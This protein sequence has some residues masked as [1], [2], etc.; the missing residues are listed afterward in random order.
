MNCELFPHCRLLKRLG[1]ELLDQLDVFE[2]ISRDRFAFGV[3]QHVHDLK[4]GFRV[5]ADNDGLQPLGF[6]RCDRAAE[7]VA[8]AAI[9]F[10]HGFYA[11]VLDVQLVLVLGFGPS[12]E[13][14]FRGFE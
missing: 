3:G 6:R 8:L 7:H 5:E 13:D 2:V 14:L 9:Q 11:D 4:P 1:R 10:F 12:I